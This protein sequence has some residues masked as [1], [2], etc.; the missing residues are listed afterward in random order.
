MSTEFSVKLGEEAY[1]YGQESEHSFG[2]SVHRLGEGPV[3]VNFHFEG[4]RHH[5]GRLKTSPEV[6]RWL[7]YALLA[8]VEG[9]AGNRA[10]KLCVKDDHIVLRSSGG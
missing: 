3:E 8:A 9:P 7:A 2:V 10:S 4:V 1:G 6:A 5:A